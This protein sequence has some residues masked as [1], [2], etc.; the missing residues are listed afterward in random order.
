ME[1]KW[2]ILCYERDNVPVHRGKA[3]KYKETWTD[4]EVKTVEELG[5]ES[6]GREE[7]LQGIDICSMSLT[8][9]NSGLQQREKTW[10]TKKTHSNCTALVSG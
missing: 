7:D 4:L 6:E 3:L 2:V 1:Q 5:D 8:Q 9:L 10:L